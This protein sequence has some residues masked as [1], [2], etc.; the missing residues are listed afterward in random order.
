[1]HLRR[2]L[3][4]SIV[5]FAVCLT[6]PAAAGQDSP[7]GDE[8]GGGPKVIADQRYGQLTESELASVDKVGA[9]VVQESV[10]ALP[11]P[12][13]GAEVYPRP[14]DG[15]YEIIGGGFGHRIGMS[16]YGADGA[17]RAGLSHREILDFY[18]PGTRLETRDYSTIR[19]GI[20]VD[21][22]GVMQVDH[23]PGLKVSSGTG[24]TAY[25]LPSG[26][27]QWRV[28]ST[29]SGSSSCVLEGKRDGQW[30]ATWPRGMSK[31]CPVTFSSADEGTVDVYLPSGDLRVYR[32]TISATYTSSG[33]VR[34]VNTVDM[35]RY[36]WSVVSSEM[37]TMFHTQA[38]RTQAVAAR[39]YAAR[40]SQGT[41]YYD[42]CD[43]TYCQVYQ[44][45]GNRNSSGSITSKEYSGNRAAV[46][47]TDGQVLSYGFSSGRALAT[48]MY[49]SSNGG[50][51]AQG[52]SAHGYLK[53]RRDPYDKVAGNSR[54]RWS[55]QLPISSLEKR[56]GIDRVER[57]QILD[58]DGDGE[59]G[60]A[61]LTA[62]VEGYTST[63]KYAYANTTGT[64]L[65]LSR[66][67][68]AW[69]GGMSSDYFT[70]TTQ[71]STPTDPPPSAEALRLGGANR[72]GTSATVAG[73]WPSGVGVAY[74]ASGAV[75]P[76]ALSAASR[77]GV[78]DAPV[79]LVDTDTVPKETAAALSKLKPARIVVVGGDKAVTDAVLKSLRSYA[80]TS[81]VD[82]VDGT[83]RYDT[84]ANMASYYSPGVRR[85]YLASGEDYPDALTG[86]ALAAHRGEPVL[87]TKAGELPAQTRAQLAR[88][89]PAEVVVIGGTR[90]VSSATAKA[91]GA[92]SDDRGFTRLAG[93]NRY[94]TAEIVAKQFPVGTRKVVVA[95]GQGFPDAI[96][97]AALGAHHAAP[98][99]LTRSDSL[100]D[101]TRDAMKTWPLT[102]A[103]VIGGTTTIA[104]KVLTSMKP[105]L[106]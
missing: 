47:A 6:G 38:L 42:T 2:Y 100:P 20:T 5:A 55:A 17:G 84:A 16:Q 60:G 75:F 54:N 76:D 44:G 49:S 98:L 71:E 48:T 4:T 89:N 62:R 25:T 45:Q 7:G 102:G 105:Y 92:Y 68:P 72:W 61:V 52:A 1:M 79:L 83:D 33:T 28:R 59:W 93:Q 27:D 32:G 26:R 65:R 9:A 43:T 53:A 22:D 99:L 82:R 36:L 66:S 87:L 57:V 23:R 56:Y 67:W 77:S 95:S 101:P 29:G 86:A 81:R 24:G 51:T 58:R 40:G 18:Y 46:D 63:G 70:F 103:Y 90:S 3:I 12:Q 85:V 69:R 35:Q 30:T 8:E 64:G 13:P 96:V 104:D 50:W 19:V 15:V 80:T 73:Q 34:T 88:L 91:A 11:R 31:A 74:V 39:T 10:T 37:P 14:D 94:D 41:S 97:G 78:Y 21:N 106:R